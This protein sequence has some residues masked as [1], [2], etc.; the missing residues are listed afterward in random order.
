MNYINYKLI[1]SAFIFAEKPLKFTE[2]LLSN[3]SFKVKTVGY[4]AGMV[5]LPITLAATP[6]SIVADIVVG[7]GEIFLCKFRGFDNDDVLEIA[8]RKILIA[9]AQQLTFLITSVAIHVLFSGF[10]LTLSIPFLLL[11]PA[12]NMAGRTFIS[13]LLP[14]CLGLEKMCIFPEEP[15]FPHIKTDPEPKEKKSLDEKLQQA[16]PKLSRIN[17]PTTPDEYIKFKEEVLK[18]SSAQGFLGGPQQI[19]EHLKNFLVPDDNNPFQ[20]GGAPQQIYKKLK[21]VLNPDKNPYRREEASELLRCLKTAYAILSKKDGAN[22][23]SED[24]RNGW[25]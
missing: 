25:L 23:V 3:K 14:N 17:S 12:S 1:P 19:Y 21:Q 11:W 8:K 9:P 18:A 15:P 22:G 24:G 10:N 4:L 5:A 7:I 6:V 16:V 20:K 13:K 2:N